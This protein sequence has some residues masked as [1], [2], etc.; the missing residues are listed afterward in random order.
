MG[1][2]TLVSKYINGNQVNGVV[3]TWG[4]GI[5][6][7]CANNT[8]KNYKSLDDAYEDG[9]IEN[10][11]KP[12]LFPREWET[13]FCGEEKDSVDTM[14]RLKVP[15]GWIVRMILILNGTPYINIIERD[16]PGHTWVLEDV[17]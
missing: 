14:Q 5:R 16:D 12:V 11:V 1:N 4:D 15:G 2:N 8:G 10:K 9:W 3:N 7:S 13:V 17:K 6:V